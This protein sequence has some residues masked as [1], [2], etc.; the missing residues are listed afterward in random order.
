VAA[1]APTI[2]V[3]A[4]GTTWVNRGAKVLYQLIVD[5]HNSCGLCCQFDRQVGPWW[6]VPFHRGCR[7]RVRPVWP[8]EA[9][10]PFVDFREKIRALPRA[11][12]SRVI[13]RSNLVLVETGVVGWDDVVTDSRV[14]SLREVVSRLG[15]SVEQMQKAGVVRRIAA[16]AYESVH[17]PA[18]A[19]AEAQR[20]EAVA[21]LGRLGLNH[22]AIA[23]EF[24]VRVAA[25]VGIGG[26]PSGPGP[27]AP[28]EAPPPKPKPKP[29]APAKA[30]PWQPTPAGEFRQFATVS[31]MEAWGKAAYGE[32]AA[33][34]SP[35]EHAALR[36]YTG[37]G[38]RAMNAA[39]RGGEPPKGAI[40]AKISALTAALNR[41]K[42][43]EGIV[44]RRGI[45]SLGDMGLDP[46]TLRVGDP[47]VMKGF[48]STTTK[49]AAT[50]GSGAKLEIRLPAGTPGAYV[51][52]SPAD[53]THPEEREF[54]LPPGVKTFRVV[55]ATKVGKVDHV[56]LELVP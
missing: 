54:L 48:V 11:Q 16:Q 35:D 7:C 36:S 32:W 45:G 21:Q 14:R 17:T 8:G 47:V 53:S 18:H 46:A 29:K 12:R 13:G 1:A 23:E 28:Q 33:G 52:A 31:E 24:G 19:L 5:W 25:K 42:L 39:L 38:Y 3:G 51:N 56:T 34:L 40:A 41:G 10:L 30:K 2:V 44:V 27:A 49:P 43:E 6:P 15:L 26:M 20:R 22:E 50:F 55:A 9:S 4:P 37:P